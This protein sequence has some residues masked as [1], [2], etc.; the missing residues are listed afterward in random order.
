VLKIVQAMP[1]ARLFLQ[2]VNRRVVT[3]YYTIVAEPID[4]G[5][6]MEK[7]RQQVYTSRHDFLEDFRLMAHNA[8]L[9]NGEFR[10]EV[11]QQACVLRAQA[12]VLLATHEAELGP[13]EQSLERFQP[14]FIFDDVKEREN[15]RLR[16]GSTIQQRKG[17]VVPPAM[18]GAAQLAAQPS[19]KLEPEDFSVPPVAYLPELSAMLPG[20][21][22]MEDPPAADLPDMP[23]ISSMPMTETG[24]TEVTEDRGQAMDTSADA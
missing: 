11:Y 21:P 10:D 14:D 7:C 20:L 19:M 2:P 3:D 12:A 22:D 24:F 1:E 18:D 17:I 6:M 4:L 8:M 13:A 16:V 5:T 9:Y 23:S 15:D